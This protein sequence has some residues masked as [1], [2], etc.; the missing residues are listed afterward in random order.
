MRNISI[1]LLQDSRFC[2]WWSKP[3]QSNPTSTVNIR[4]RRATHREAFFLVGIGKQLPLASTG[5]S[6]RPFFAFFFVEPSSG[7]SDRIYKVSQR[8][9]SYMYKLQVK[10]RFCYLSFAKT[11]GRHSISPNI[12][13]LFYFSNRLIQWGRPVLFHSRQRYQ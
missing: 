1:F 3:H 13:S 11:L 10:V 12:S 5:F 2:H 4:K 6:G 9:K 8:Y 7:R